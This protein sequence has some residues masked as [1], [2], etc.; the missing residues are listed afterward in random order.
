LK[1][2]D[3]TIRDRVL[4]RIVRWYSSHTRIE[5]A[6]GLVRRIADDTLR[7]DALVMLGGAALASKDT[8]RAI[9]LL[10][11]AE[12]CSLKTRPS[13]ERAD[14][15]VKIASTF[16]AFDVVRSFEVLQSAVKSI[17]EIISQQKD[18]E[19]KSSAVRADATQAFTLDGLYA[20]SFESMLATLGKADFD[21][22]LVLAQQLAPEEASLIAQL[23]VCR[24]GLTEK[25]PSERSAGDDETESGVNH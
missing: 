25:P 23:A 20:A 16:A 19:G 9:E 18:S 24:G 7:V 22:A 12:S 10:N 1:I 6:V 17:N 13:P 3:G 4:T 21:R 8:V 5:D 2:S 15:L 14:S 11:Q